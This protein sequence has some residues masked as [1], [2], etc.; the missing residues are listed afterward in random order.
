M[1]VANKYALKDVISA[2]DYY[3]KKTGRRVSS[4]YSLVAGVNDTRKEVLLD[5]YVT[6]AYGQFI[7]FIEGYKQ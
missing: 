3:F 6:G 1:P 4:E 2:C 7:N 5:V